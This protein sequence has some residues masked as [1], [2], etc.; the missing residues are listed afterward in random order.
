MNIILEENNS[1][2]FEGALKNHMGQVIDHFRK[3]LVGIRSGRAH[4]S[5]IEDTLVTCYN[6][7]STLRLKEIA[8]LS[9]PDANLL[10]I[11]P[12]DKSLISDVE[13]SITKSD[14]GFNPINDGN[15][16]RIQLP[17]MSTE[18][19]SELIK[20]LHKKTE[21]TRINLRNVRKEFH[22][23]VRDKERAKKISE[24][25]AKRIMDKLQKETDLHIG[26]AEE[27]MKKKE[28]EIK[29]V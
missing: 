25:F 29:S 7:A 20:T 28:H 19:R 26:L 18:R 4:V 3:E 22:N 2:S 6:G 13:K 9:A 15:L 23:I 8:A 10:I 12:W 24:D 16:I 21:E 14:Q 11:E 5:M 17:I 27:I 1:T